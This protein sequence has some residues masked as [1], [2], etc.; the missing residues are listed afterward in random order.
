[1]APR[2]PEPIL[3]VDMDAFYASVEA[4]KDPDPPG[5]PGGGGRLRRPGVVMSA[6]TRLG[7]HGVHSAMP[8]A[9][10]AACAPDLVFVRPGLDAYRGGVRLRAILRS[11][12]PLVEPC[13]WTRRS[14]TSG[15]ARC[16]APPPRIARAGPRAGP[17]RHATHRLGGGGPEQVPGEARLRR[18][19]SPTGWYSSPADGVRCASWIRCRWTRC[20]AWERRRDE[21]LLKLGIRTVAELAETSSAVLERVLG[22]QLSRHPLLPG[23]RGGRPGRGP[24]EAPKSVSHEETF[25]RDV[26]DDQDVLREVLRLSHRVAA[27]LRADGY[28]AR[29]ITLKV[30]LSNFTTLTRSRTLADPTDSAA[31]LYRVA[32]EAYRGPALRPPPDPAPG[33]RGQR[34]LRGGRRAARPVSRGTVAG[35]GGRPRPDRS[36]IRPGDRVPGRAVG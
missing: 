35:G 29:T 7:R 32:S 13:R 16:S 24:L 26:D 18:G 6:S 21:V 10:P 15:S 8:S 4:L 12:T 5:R 28:R 31:D 17:D 3:H 14:S 33:R 36:T 25:E 34:A 1:M 23:S 20:G 30:R 19:P 11:F 22:E 2:P 9:G 27:R